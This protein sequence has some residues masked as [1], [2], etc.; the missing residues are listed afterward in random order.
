MLVAVSPLAT[1]AKLAL[2]EGRVFSIGNQTQHA[3]GLAACGV[4][5]PGRAVLADG[6]ATRRATPAAWRPILN[7][8][9]ARSGRGDL[10]AETA[11]RLVPKE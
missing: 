4:H 8:K 1:L 11:N 3:L 2:E 10:D 5:R 7:D 6:V 9:G